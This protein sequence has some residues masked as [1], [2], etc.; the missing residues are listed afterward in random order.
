[1]GDDFRVFGSPISVPAFGKLSGAPK[2]NTGSKEVLRLGEPFRAPEK[3]IGSIF[4]YSTTS[5]GSKPANDSSFASWNPKSHLGTTK[6][7]SND[8]S[9]DA[10]KVPPFGNPFGPVRESDDVPP[11]PDSL[12]NGSYFYPNGDSI[13]EGPDGSVTRRY[14]DGT[15]IETGSDG[16]SV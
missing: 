11:D 10:T 12:R 4:R 14:H 2:K 13:H 6:R 16:I 15:V 1:M 5:D 8:D 7:T 9:I 3:N